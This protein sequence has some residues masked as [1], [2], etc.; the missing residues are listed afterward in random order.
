MCAATP[1]THEVNSS[2]PLAIVVLPK[3]VF[4]RKSPRRRS[5][6]D[7]TDVNPYHLLYKSFY[8]HK[9][10]VTFI[11]GPQ[12]NTPD[13]RV[14]VSLLLLKV[15]KKI[16][17]RAPHP[18]CISFSSPLSSTPSTG[19]PAREDQ[20]SQG[21]ASAPPPHPAESPAPGAP[22]HPGKLHPSAD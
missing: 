2:Q 21:S 5:K 19:C 13:S 9:K 10:C 14:Q 11:V 3:N 8:L 20:G 4:S 12:L 17:S 22:T 15:K 16:L 7:P 18:S 6:V 1:C